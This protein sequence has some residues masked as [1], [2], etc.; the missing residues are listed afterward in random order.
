MVSPRY[1][2]SIPKVL[3]DVYHSLGTQLPEALIAVLPSDFFSDESLA[4]DSVSVSSSPF[5]ATQ[6]NIS[7]IGDYLEELRNRSAKKRR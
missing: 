6:S 5:S 7:S 2:N 3:A 4:K 1:L